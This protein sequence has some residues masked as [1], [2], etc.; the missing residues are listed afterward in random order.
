MGLYTGKTA[1]VF[2]VAN[3][4]SIAWGI[5]QALHAEGAEI[6]FSYAIPDLEKRVGPLAKSL[7]SKLVEECDV[8]NDAALDQIFEKVTSTYGTIDVLVHSIA[9]AEREDLAGRF[10][11]TGRKG[12]K[13]AL[14]ISAYSLVALAQRAE[15]LMPDGGAMLAMT[16]I[17]GERVLPNYNVMGV[18]KAALESCVRYLAADLGP[19]RIRVNAISAGPI[20]TLAASG[21]AGFRAMYRQH[22]RVAPLRELVTQEDVG[23]TALW[24]CSDQ[25]RMVTGQVVY[26]DSGWSILGFTGSLDDITLPE[27]D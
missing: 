11:E 15:K 18:A 21:V 2:G 23:Q 7:S 13:T 14:E 27:S 25:A 5:A 24:L 16:A 12:F 6:A 26:V 19:S 1:L 22:E 10:V 8:T 3:K 4:Y 20:K 9:F 17:G